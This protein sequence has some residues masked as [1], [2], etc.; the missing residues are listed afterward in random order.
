ML[1][2]NEPRLNQGLD[3]LEKRNRERWKL[4]LLLLERK[5]RIRMEVG[6][7][8]AEGRGVEESLGV[9][10]E[11]GEYCFAYIFY[12]GRYTACLIQGSL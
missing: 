4:E 3:W 11:C 5:K 9:E 10:C 8:Y 2:N 1:R 6:R 12:I 7:C